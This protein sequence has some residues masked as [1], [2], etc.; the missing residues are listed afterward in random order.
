MRRLLGRKVKAHPEDAAV[1]VALREI[2]R[3]ALALEN[4]LGE[5]LLWGSEQHNAYRRV[6]DDA[7]IIGEM[8]WGTPPEH[9]ST[10]RTAS[11]KRRDIAA[12]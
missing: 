9:P 12:R 6:V 3:R 7:R 8:Q 4:M 2:A 11:P 10:V 1:R 5:G